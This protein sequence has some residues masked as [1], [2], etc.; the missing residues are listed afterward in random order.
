MPEG[1]QPD[2]TGWLLQSALE[3]IVFLPFSAGT[4]SHFEHDLY[5]AELPPS[6]WQKKWWEY[7]ASSRASSRPGAAKAISATPAPRPTSTTTPAQ[8]YDYALATM[9][10]FQLHDHICSKILKQDVRAC[11]YSGNKEV[12][13]FLQGILSLGATRDWR[14]VIKEA[15]GE[16]ISPRAMMAFYQPLVDV[17]AKRNEGRDC[18][19]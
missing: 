4:M 1:K 5:E 8:Y 12:G 3:S 18:G 19:R 14:A 10:K 7:V 2:P 15:T 9:I 11:D 6:E 13:D 16:P 17:L